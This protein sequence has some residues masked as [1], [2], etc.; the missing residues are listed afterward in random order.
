M[1]AISSKKTPYIDRNF[2]NAESLLSFNSNGA[3]GGQYIETQNNPNL[4]LGRDFSIE[5]IF[6]IDSG[7]SHPRVVCG[8]WQFN[9]APFGFVV[10]V[11]GNNRMQFSVANQEAGTNIN[12]RSALTDIIL[13]TEIMY[14]CV[15]TYSSSNIG[16]I[17]IN[18]RKSAESTNMAT[19]SNWG[20]N[21]PILIGNSFNNASNN[22]FQGKIGCF[23][24]YDDFL[25]QPDRIIKMVRNP[26]FLI[27]ELKSSVTQ[28]FLLN[29]RY[30]SVSDSNFVSNN[31][32]FS[33]GDVIAI[34]SV[35]NYDY[36]KSS[37][38]TF[39]HGKI[40]GKTS[41]E[42]SEFPEPN[43][44]KDFYLTNNQLNWT[45]DGGINELNGLPPIRK[46][47]KF[48]GI[49]QR[50]FI[51]NF[52]PS[53]ENGYSHIVIYKNNRPS[54]NS[55][56]TLYNIRNVNS[57]GNSDGLNLNAKNQLIN[58]PVVNFANGN[59]TYTTTG[60]FT[61]DINCL[62][63][64]QD[65]VLGHVERKIFINGSL[66]FTEEGEIEFSIREGDYSNF[67]NPVLSIFANSPQTLFT[68]SDLFFYGMMKGKIKQEHILEIFNN[69]FPKMPDPS[70]GYEWQ[71]LL[72]LN[73]PI[74]I[75]TTPKIRNL[76]QTINPTAPQYDCI[77]QGFNSN[78]LD[79][80]NASYVFKDMNTLR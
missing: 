47:L 29:Q 61:D 71:V 43:D 16:T 50:L 13:K 40:I 9:I 31:P 36:V 3:V 80:T 24:F 19:Q 17:Y 7:F 56:Q 49:N 20:N 51:S 38:A 65:V 33:L 12:S 1:R 66:E 5:F 21:R 64:T 52:N 70:W 77:M 63:Q 46:G 74:D 6:S 4:G 8:N 2:V 34:N 67:S 11:N 42:I 72:D 10:F 22:S 18:G 37:I 78:E 62:C 76:A 14:H 32:S 23:R 54:I 35:S 53:G 73:M 79:E 48:N 45:S 25:L 28:E 68:E 15:I 27:R 55:V 57:T 59:R 44:V 75:E 58:R 41:Q 30:Y 60:N 26:Y 39:D 69:G